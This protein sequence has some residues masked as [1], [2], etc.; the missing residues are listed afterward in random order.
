MPGVRKIADPMTFVI[1]IS[2][3]LPRPMART[4][5]ASGS[6]GIAADG[7]SMAVCVSRGTGESE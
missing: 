6:A 1:T 2:V 4:S 5:F 3:A 7:A